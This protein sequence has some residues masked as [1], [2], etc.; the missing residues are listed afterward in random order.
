MLYFPSIY[1]KKSKAEGKKYN[2]QNSSNIISLKKSQT[3]IPNWLPLNP[4]IYHSPIQKI[5]SAKIKYSK[6]ITIKLSTR[7]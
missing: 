3:K 4:K 6:M 2:S 7:H 5:Q 1:F